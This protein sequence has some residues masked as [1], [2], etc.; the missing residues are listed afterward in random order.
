MKNLSLTKQSHSWQ[1][2]KEIVTILRYY[3][4][5]GNYGQAKLKFHKV[6][7]QPGVDRLTVVRNA[8]GGGHFTLSDNNFCLIKIAP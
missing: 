3:R 7:I 1:Q 2:V 6:V 5:M 4:R 8:L